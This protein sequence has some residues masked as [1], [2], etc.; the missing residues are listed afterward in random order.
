VTTRGG[1][2]AVLRILRRGDVFGE[3]CLARK[4]I[5][6]ATATAVGLATIRQVRTASIVRA[7]RENS[8]FA[9]MFVSHLL[10]RIERVEEELVD[11]ILNSSE[12]RL[13]RALLTMAGAGARSMRTETLQNI[14]Q[15]TLAELVG[16]TRSR[17]SYFMN[18]FRRL[19]LIEY[20]G[21]LRI[22]RGLASYLKRQ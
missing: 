9:K 17:V 15:R 6:N 22:H 13:A 18:R 2:T 10:L 1:K 14:D 7:I 5:R 21:V 19:G 4:R 12:K 16:T 11:Q 3:E 8:A 20:N